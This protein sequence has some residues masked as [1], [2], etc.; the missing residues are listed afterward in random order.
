MFTRFE[1]LELCQWEVFKLIHETWYGCYFG[2][3]GLITEVKSGDAPRSPSRKS[4]MLGSIINV[5]NVAVKDLKR[6][7]VA[8]NS[9]DDPAREA[10]NFTSQVFIMNHPG[11]VGNGY[12]PVLDCHTS[13]I[14]VKFAEILT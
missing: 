13:H 1:V 6:G 9:K 2:P 3:T 4:E 7:F 11:Q 5:K 8:S 10:T 12:T 14:A